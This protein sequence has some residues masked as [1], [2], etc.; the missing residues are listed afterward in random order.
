MAVHRKL[1]ARSRRM[2]T[3]GQSISHY[4]LPTLSST[5]LLCGARSMGG[6]GGGGGGGGRL[7]TLSDSACHKSVGSILRIPDVLHTMWLL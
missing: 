4:R 2:I 1:V 7:L 3:R 6:G 5:G